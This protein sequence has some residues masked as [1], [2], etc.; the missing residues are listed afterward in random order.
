MSLD[1]EEETTI[2]L[3]ITV[4]AGTLAGVIS[5]VVLSSSASGYFI[6]TTFVVSVVDDVVRVRL[7]FLSVKLF[8]E[9]IHI[10]CVWSN[11]LI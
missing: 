7:G 9:T 5:E 1:E 2:T 4:P 6:F 11:E 8:Y 3:T 10:F